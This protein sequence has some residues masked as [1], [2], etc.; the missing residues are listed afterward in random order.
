MALLIGLSGP[1]GGGK[2]TL[3]S[4]LS[5]IFGLEIDRFAK[6]LYEM[7]AVVDPTI[8]PSMPHAKKEAPLLDNPAYGTRREFLQKLGTEFGRNLIHQDLWTASCLERAK[9]IPTVIA[10]VRF[11]SEAQAIRDAGG[12]VIH[13][14]PDWTDFDCKHASSKPLKVIGKDILVT[15]TKGNQMSDFEKVAELVVCATKS[16]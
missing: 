13:L 15:L 8:H 2:D 3:A 12:M 11:E 16:L 14:R 5:Q 6:T 9:H 1:A 4:Y 7:A 10:D